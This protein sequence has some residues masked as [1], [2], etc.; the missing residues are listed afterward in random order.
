MNKEKREKI[1]LVILHCEMFIYGTNDPFLSVRA[2]Y[3]TIP[4]FYNIFCLMHLIS[5]MFLIQDYSEENRPMSG[6]CYRTLKPLGLGDLL[7]PIQKIMDTPLGNTTFGDYIRR[8]RAKLCT[9]GDLSFK[10]LPGEEQKI[11]S[12]NKEVLKFQDLME[13][14]IQ[15]VIILK[16]K[17]EKNIKN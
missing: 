5:T 3:K 8:S 16:E 14:L 9:H 10:S 6:F 4:W 12:N 11:T 17:L 7:K 1:E 15:E 2:K 13:K